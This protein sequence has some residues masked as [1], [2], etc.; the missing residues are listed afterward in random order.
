MSSL[1]VQCCA[2][3]LEMRELKAGEVLNLDRRFVTGGDSDA[4]VSRQA[5]CAS[6]FDRS[7]TWF[8]HNRS[9]S[10]DL[11]LM[12][13]DGRQYRIAPGS[14]KEITDAYSE[15]FV[16]GS[17]RVGLT[18]KADVVYHREPLTAPT[19]VGEIPTELPLEL[20][21][22]QELITY[23]ENE[24]HSTVTF[25]RYFEFIPGTAPAGPH[26]KP[27][28][29]AEVV[30]CNPAVTEAQ[31]NQIQR[32]IKKIIGLDA[33]ATGAWLADRGILRMNSKIGLPHE[34]CR[35]RPL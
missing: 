13:E 31:V 11:Q 34:Q 28:T 24:R 9:P 18:L 5:N 8:V 16:G 33:D 7:G 4:S 35:H 6:L 19:A 10:R 32:D 27:L 20:D 12:S 23:L 3:T 1:V 30:L 2:G 17:H 25:L 22:E 29:A 21:R 14:A 26:P 15:L